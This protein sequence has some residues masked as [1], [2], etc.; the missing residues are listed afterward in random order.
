MHIDALARTVRNAAAS[1][2][3]RPTRG[4]AAQDREV[5]AADSAAAG[6]MVA[7]MQKCLSGRPW[8]LDSNTGF[9]FLRHA[10]AGIAA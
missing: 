2:L 9:L 4:T 1:L 3:E 8:S 6:F 10:M 5:G 7:L